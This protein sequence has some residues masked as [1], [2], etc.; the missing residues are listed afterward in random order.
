V[1][2][3][4]ND[5]L[6]AHFCTIIGR[7]DL[8]QHPK[9]STNPLRTNNRKALEAILNEEIGKKTTREWALLF[10]KEGIPYSPVNDLKQICEDPHIQYRKMLVE[11]AQPKVGR[12]KIAGSP[13][14]LS[15][16]PGDVR[17][18]APSLGEHTEE[19]LTSVLNMPVERITAL[20]EEGVIS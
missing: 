12:I 10:E 20:R 3:L 11:V 1:I 7:P 5:K 2:P 15:E 19:V 6:W 13:L 9:F 18:G 14:H 4:G 16:T 8:V 17:S